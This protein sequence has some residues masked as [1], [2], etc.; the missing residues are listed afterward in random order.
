ME[1]SDYQRER[2][3]LCR[4]GQVGEWSPVK[5]GG[6]VVLAIH[7]HLKHTAIWTTTEIDPCQKESTLHQAQ[8]TTCHG[9]TYRQRAYIYNDS[10]LIYL[11][12]S[13]TC[14]FRWKENTLKIQF[15]VS[16]NRNRI[17]IQP[18]NLIPPSVCRSTCLIT[19]KNVFCSDVNVRSENCWS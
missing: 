18:K 17:K 15:C 2:N 6:K 11:G 3:R 19:E 16:Q 7:R 12:S 5:M 8:H 1:C 9:T 10:L 13:M 14:C 4:K